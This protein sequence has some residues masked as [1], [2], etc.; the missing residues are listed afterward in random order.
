MD[1]KMLVKYSMI[2]EQM[3]KDIKE[4]LA[5]VKQQKE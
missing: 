3:A 5:I 2:I 1:L 4:I